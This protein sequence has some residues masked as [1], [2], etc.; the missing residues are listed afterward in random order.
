[1]CRSVAFAIV[2][3]LVGCRGDRAARIDPPVVA[4]VVSEPALGIDAIEH[5]VTEPIEQAL[6][7]ISSVRSIRSES[8]AGLSTVVAELADETGYAD[9]RSRIEA[10]HARLPEGAL[11]QLSRVAPDAP[12]D[13][14][15]AVRGTRSAVELTRIAH[16][17][18]IPRVE[19]LPGVG[20]VRVRGGQEHRFEVRVDPG[21]LDALGLTVLEVADAL[22]E[23]VDVPAGQLDTGQTVRVVDRASDTP[24]QLRMRIIGQRGGAPFRLGD[25][26]TLQEVPVPPHA[27]PLELGIRFMRGTD[28]TRLASQ[29]VQ[30]VR[31]DVPS[32]VS[33]TTTPPVARA[34]RVTLIGDD[35]S[36]VAHAADEVARA[37][38]VEVPHEPTVE[39]TID[40]E[41]AAAFGISAAELSRAIAVALGE[42]VARTSDGADVVLHVPELERLHVRGAQGA[43][44]ELTR[45][46]TRRTSDGEVVRLRIDRRP[47]VELTVPGGSLADVRRRVAAASVPA[48]IR[49]Q[50]R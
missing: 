19:R 42:P 45:L 40:R 30:L 38:G 43:L 18:I 35:R 39:M 23:N 22:A 26:A 1:M 47:A 49:V 13:L 6:G 4:I 10:I 32:G 41:R 21:R 31:A 7:G 50:V 46:V 48:A 44:V 29:I 17:W 11:P 33:I 8:R 24:E 3:A 14:V 25:V 34:P 20:E 27:E 2:V 5:A 28:R 36:A 12:D 37:L 9:A 15:L 16:D